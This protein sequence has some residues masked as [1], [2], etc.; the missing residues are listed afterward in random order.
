MKKSSREN[1]IFEL[2]KNS[3]RSA[4]LCGEF[5][6]PESLNEQPFEAAVDNLLKS[7][8]HHY[9]KF[10]ESM[11]SLLESLK[12]ECFCMDDYVEAI[13][14]R[15]NENGAEET[16]FEDFYKPFLDGKCV[17][18]NFFEIVFVKSEGIVEYMLDRVKELY[19]DC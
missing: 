4:V 8:E 2:L 15:L 12:T 6:T 16:D 18:E 14:I 5:H 19:G 3:T 13:K 7:F 17:R 9:T 1:Q 10:M 11:F